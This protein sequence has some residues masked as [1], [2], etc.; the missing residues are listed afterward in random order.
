MKLGSGKSFPL[1]NENI[2]V[3]ATSEENR[4]ECHLLIWDS[5]SR[6]TIQESS[7]YIPKIINIKCL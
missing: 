1:H 4:T 3:V 7:R 6:K 5:V 2:G